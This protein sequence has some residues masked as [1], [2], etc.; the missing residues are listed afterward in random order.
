MADVGVQAT[1]SIVEQLEAR[2]RPGGAETSDRA[3]RPS[4]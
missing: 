4:C 2:G 3:A 1:V